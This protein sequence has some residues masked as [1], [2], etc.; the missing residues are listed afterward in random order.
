MQVV[1]SAKFPKG[2]Q[3]KEVYKNGGPK[4][5]GNPLPKSEVKVL[6]LSPYKSYKQEMQVV[7][8]EDTH[9][10][11]VKKEVPTGKY[12]LVKDEISRWQ[13]FDQS[14]IK[15][16]L[17]QL[18]TPYKDA[19]GVFMRAPQAWKGL[20]EEEE[21]LRDLAL[22]NAFDDVALGPDGLK[23]VA[24]KTAR[25]FTQEERTV[26]VKKEE[27]K[28]ETKERRPAKK[29]KKAAKTPKKEARD[30]NLFD[31]VDKAEYERLKE[32]EKTLV[33][34]KE[35][36]AGHERTAEERR[37]EI[38]RLEREAQELRGVKAKYDALPLAAKAMSHE[39]LNEYKGFE[40]KYNTFAAC[41][42]SY[43]EVELR[44]VNKEHKQNGTK[45]EKLEDFVPSSIMGMFV[46]S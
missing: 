23:R 11:T 35:E 12:T 4:F 20:T 27:E 10:G 18:G 33:K 41:V 14:K 1:R 34:L 15:C 21:K 45:Q 31:V 46:P 13:W 30:E 32:A 25:K 28:T 37:K 24:E 40:Q 44:N 8:V 2:G 22:I 39:A 19:T 42:K 9:A 38:V 16:Y 3:Y 5:S 36:S 43:F 7:E 29:A 26:T 17:P 6:L